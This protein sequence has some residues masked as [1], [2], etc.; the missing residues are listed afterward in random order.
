VAPG[1]AGPVRN[2]AVDGSLGSQY[3]PEQAEIDG[4]SADAPPDIVEEQGTRLTSSVTPSLMRNTLDHPY[5]PTDGSRQ[6]PR[7]ELAGLGG[8]TDFVKL[9]LEARWFVPTWTIAGHQARLVGGRR[10]G[11]GPG[12]QRPLR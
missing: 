2:L 10:A 6:S 9:E 12:R 8:E 4:V 3:R 11:L 7:Q 5:D 1:F